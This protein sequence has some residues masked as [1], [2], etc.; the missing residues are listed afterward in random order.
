MQKQPADIDFSLTATD[1][2]EHIYCPRFSYFEKL[3]DIPEHQEKRFKVQKGRDVH[4]DKTRVNPDYLRKKIGCRERRHE[5]Y[6]ASS[7]G[8]RGVVDEILFLE[9]G[10]A[11]PLDYKFA[12]YKDTVF[13][14]HKLQL[15]FYGVL[16]S[17]NYGIQVNRGYIVYVRSKNKIV[18]VELPAKVYT[19][20]QQIVSDFLEVVLK[21]K[22]PRPTKY[23]SRCPDCCYNNICEQVI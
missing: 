13:K 15:A 20:L 9:D 6:L 16:I 19:E 23:K 11:A 7:R 17:D 2:L 8:L 10:T 22:Y 1:I 18:E 3:L 14:N 21:G 4:K 5:V 12:P